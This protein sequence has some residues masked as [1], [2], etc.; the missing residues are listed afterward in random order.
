MLKRFRLGVIY[1]QQGRTEEEIQYTRRRC[2]STPTMPKR[3]TTLV[4]SRATGPHDEAI[5]EFQAALRINPSHAEAHLILGVAYMEQDRL[6]EAIQ[7]FQAA[8]KVNPDYAE[9]R[10]A[11]DAAKMQR[12]TETT[13]EQADITQQVEFYGRQL[14]F[15]RGMFAMEPGLLPPFETGVE[16]V[17]MRCLAPILKPGS[18]RLQECA[19][20]FQMYVN[21][22]PGADICPG[23]T[24]YTCSPIR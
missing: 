10:F 3:T 14:E 13:E 16:M 4:W 5:Q 24:A 17:I 9:A 15:E 22:R 11:L 1:G 21:F 18:N 20:P 23:A 19:Q 2:G 12:L 7:E 8:L 6:D